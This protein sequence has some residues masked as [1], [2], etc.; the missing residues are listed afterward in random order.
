MT[1]QQLQQKVTELIIDAEL[2][3][4]LT[5]IALYVRGEYERD[6]ILLKSNFNTKARR[7]RSGTM[8]ADDFDTFRNQT[9]ENLLILVTTSLTEKDINPNGNQAEPTSILV[10]AETKTELTYMERLIKLLKI[11]KAN[12]E[13]QLA[14]DVTESTSHKLR[15]Y[16]NRCIGDLPNPSA[17]ER[18]SEMDLTF[19]N[20][21][22]ALLTRD[23][24]AITEQSANFYMMHFGERLFLLNHKDW[25]ENM[26][27]VNSKFSFKARVEEI[28]EYIR[29]TELEEVM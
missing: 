3:E 26:I 2:E 20:K 27:A 9:A 5:L 16:D 24:K 12:F 25:R 17:L 19:V 15:I 14:K 1:L 7:Y 22:I 11:E 23:F 8:S 29:L 6:F 10:I 18:L 28:L 13:Y 21:R 4:A